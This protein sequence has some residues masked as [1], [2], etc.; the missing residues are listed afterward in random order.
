MTGENI[1]NSRTRTNQAS[2]VEKAHSAQDRRLLLFIL[3]IASLIGIFWIGLIAAWDHHDEPSH[4]QYVRRLVDENRVPT[5]G[6]ENWK[7][8]R[9]ILKSMIWNGFFERM[10]LLPVLPAPKEPVFIPG[11]SQYEE[12]PAYY[13]AASLAVRLLLNENITRQMFGAR[14]VS[15]GFYLLTVLAA[16]GIAREITSFGHPLR[17][18]LPLSVTFFPALVD[19]MTAVNNDSGSI[20]VVSF[21]I[22]ICLRLIKKGLNVLDLLAG[23]GLAVLAWFMKSTSALVIPL[24]PL[25]ILFAVFRNKAR[26]WVWAFLVL[27]VSLGVGLSLLKDDAAFYYRSVAMDSPTRVQQV[28]APYGNWVLQVNESLG[29]TPGWMPS[30][31]QPIPFQN[32]VTNIGQKVTLGFWMW[33]DQAVEA[34]TPGLSTE[35]ESR[36][37]TV[38]LSQTPVFYTVDAIIDEKARLWLTIDP[39]Q[40]NQG[41]TVFLDGLVLALGDRPLDS[42]PI[43]NDQTA[44]TGT[45]GSEPFEN[46]I[47]NGSIEE[48]S[49]RVRSWVDNLIARFYPDQIRPSFMLMSALDR[50]G[51]GWYYNLVFRNMF[52]TFVGYF[53]WDHIHLD[54]PSLIVILEILILIGLI[55]SMVGLVIYRRKVDWAVVVFM[56]VAVGIA[57]LAT[58]PRGIVFLAF[59]K[60][61]VPVGRYL[62]PVI[63]PIMVGVNMGWYWIGQAFRGITRK[64][65]PPELVN[66]SSYSAWGIGIYGGFC[67]LVNLVAILSIWRYYGGY[68][69]LN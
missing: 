19:V 42:P 1:V 43:F 57:L 66:P 24:F 59:P 8:N 55:A 54:P 14:I 21:F 65:S 56:L 41:V 29:T 46:M 50:E 33:A 12:P 39:F 47:R 52:A 25:A 26:K 23:L 18:M 10:N 3:L 62:M 22:W 67:F 45:W 28:N 49:L 69:L 13:Y 51:T 48:D 30:L 11:Y 38:Q 16:W 9:Q 20:A 7:L 15:F 44:Q 6:E 60:I 53:G 27:I 68:H 40:N 32:T 35:K 5:P 58:I 4:F 17:W 61:Y 64:G 31:F 63:I 36:Y 34:R 37:K 2:D